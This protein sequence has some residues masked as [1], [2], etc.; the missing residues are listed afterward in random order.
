MISWIL[1]G[2]FFLIG[3][4]ILIACISASIRNSSSG[5][6]LLEGGIGGVVICLLVVLIVTTSWYESKLVLPET[7]VTIITTIKE[8]KE[9]VGQRTLDLSDVQIDKTIAEL[10]KEKNKLLKRI[11]INNKSPF[12]LFK[13]QVK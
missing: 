4:A 9:L 13:I 10:I 12:A 3:L 8:T 7:Y 5:E 11:R 2:I 6:G 1:C